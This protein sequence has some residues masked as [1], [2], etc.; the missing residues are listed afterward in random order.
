MAINMSDEPMT[1]AWHMTK[2]RKTGGRIKGTPN[3]ATA[4]VKA[5]AS[6]YGLEAVN[7]LVRIMNEGESEQA[8]IA[9]AKELLDRGYGRPRQTLDVNDS[10]VNVYVQ[11]GIVG[12]EA[13][14]GEAER[15]ADAV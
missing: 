10:S 11:R 5:L 2:R 9:A 4:D 15:L 7:T 13:I 8:R 1:G 12:P 3:K 6:P 14:E